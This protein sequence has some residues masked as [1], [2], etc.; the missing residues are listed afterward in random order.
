MG[1]WGTAEDLGD[2]GMRDQNQ[3]WKFGR[4]LSIDFGAWAWLSES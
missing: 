3:G 4:E 1:V 2:Q